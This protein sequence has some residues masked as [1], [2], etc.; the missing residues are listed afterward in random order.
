MKKRTFLLCFVAF[1][2]QMQ[3]LNAQNS[4]EPN[5]R[6]INSAHLGEQSTKTL[7]ENIRSTPNSANLIKQNLPQS[8]LNLANLSEQNLP[9]SS[10]NSANLSTQNA[11][12][13]T[14][15]LANSNAQITLENA[16]AKAKAHYPLHK[17]KELLAR[18]QSLELTR[19]N[20]NYIPQIR[21]SAKATYQSDVTKLP[22]SSAALSQMAG[23]SIDYKPLNKDQ[24]N[25]NIEIS[26]PLLDS[27]SVWA[28]K[29]TVSARYASRSAE[30]DSALYGIQNLV[31][32]SYFSALLLD[33]QIKQSSIHISELEK[34]L[35]T[36]NARYQNG[37]ANK[38]DIDK[39]RVQILQAQKSSQSLQNERDIA[40]Q[41]LQELIGASENL[42]L[43]APNLD[44]A[45]QYLSAVERD[46]AGANFTHRPEMQVFALKTDEIALQK[47]QEIAR[48]LPYIDAFLQVGY[49]NPA[50]NILHS[51]FDEYYIAG[52][53]LNWNLSN[54]YSTRQQNELRRVQALEIHSQRE[55]FL[56]NARIAL[57][58]H[59]K[60][61]KSLLRTLA[62]DEQIISAQ[63]ELAKS[64]AARLKNGVLSTNDFLSEINEL[65]A[66][67]LQH[68]Y[69]E[70]EFL[71]ETMQIRQ[72]LNDWA[73]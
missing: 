25:A 35:K 18:A 29:S 46:L 28:N 3:I 40:L 8:T 2:S 23:A 53:R 7:D 4:S 55:E 52:I 45:R 50:L 16:I 65:N 71:L 11:P 27:G 60:K 70:T 61:A 17:N 47:R 64:A 5:L 21:L 26:Q 43:V 10:L 37:V 57:K 49:A 58:Q 62:Q 69:D 56:F 31:I 51:G 33:K 6:A 13:D 30:L 1:C 36:L 54:L 12:Q 22:F 15:N 14:L 41:T 63:E 72:T 48:S 9:Q 67:K 44:E 34:N 24:Y 39:I 20:M 38:S 68:N 42:Q 73:Q 19:L 66:L 59:I 32:N